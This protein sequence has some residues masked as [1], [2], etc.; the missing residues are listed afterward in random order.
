[1][2]TY[3]TKGPI[4][5]DLDVAIGDIRVRAGDHDDTT[6]A[7]R[8]SDARNEEDRRAAERTVLERQGQHVHVRTP[9]LGLLTRKGGSVDVTVALP[10]G[11]ELKAS[12][13]TADFTVEGRLGTCR[14][15]VGLGSVHLGET[16]DLQVKC[17]FGDIHVERIAGAASITAGSGDVRVD[18]AD[19]STF[20]KAGNG[21]TWL[22]A[23]GGELQVKAANGDVRIEQATGAVTVK[24]ANGDLR[25]GRAGGGPIELQSGAGDIEVGIPE[26][27]PAWLDVSAAY[28][29]L[30]NQ[31]EA[32]SRPAPDAPKVE[33]RARTTAGNIAIRR[34]DAPVA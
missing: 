8:P 2:P 14:V 31:L 17:G 34:P 28:G 4:T 26:G 25:V 32:S 18:E 23:I 6:V 7:V 33:V 21:D 27:T 22:G 1:M 13:Q 29:R 11:S 5:I 10:A 20:V 9:K 15:T 24:T 30:D 16:A 3:D 19:G 12:G